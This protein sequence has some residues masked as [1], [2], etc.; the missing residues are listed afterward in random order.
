M[1]IRFSYY[2]SGAAS[3]R[4]DIDWDINTIGVNITPGPVRVVV[5][6]QTSIGTVKRLNRLGGRTV[7]IT[8]DRFSAL[9]AV[10]QALYRDLLAMISHLELG[11]SVAF[12]L[13][14]SKM[15]AGWGMAPE[16]GDDFIN[17]SRNALPPGLDS[18]LANWEAGDE[19]LIQGMQPLAQSELVVYA[20]GAGMSSTRLNLSDTVRLS[21]AEQGPVLIR[22]RDYYPVLRMPESAVGTSR[23]TQDFRLNSTLDLPLYEDIGG[24]T[25]QSV[26]ERIFT[27]SDAIAQAG[28]R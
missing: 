19:L 9:D 10:G 8:I 22:P 1:S 3:T 18:N 25:K 16:T 4:I 28:K 27:E 15:A 7:T 13:D 23:L 5:D 24:Y 20:S 12:A 11:N 21:Y 2:P 17:W 14:S 26:G 6:Q